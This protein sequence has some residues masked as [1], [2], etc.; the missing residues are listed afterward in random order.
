[1]AH[2]DD[3]DTWRQVH[4]HLTLAIA[5]SRDNIAAELTK[6]RFLLEEVSRCKVQPTPNSGGGGGAAGKK[7]AAPK[8][9]ATTATS[10]GKKLPTS[11]KPTQGAKALPVSKKSPIKKAM[12]VKSTIKAKTGKSKLL[13]T[14]AN[15][16]ANSSSDDDDI[17]DNEDEDDMDES[18]SDDENNY[19]STSKSHAPLGMDDNDSSDDNSD[20]SSGGYSDDSEIASSPNQKQQR[21]EHTQ[22]QMNAVSEAN[23]FQSGYGMGGKTMLRDGEN[24]YSED[25][26]SDFDF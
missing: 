15:L 18:D 20:D 10:K 3:L 8:K 17:L 6:R 25:E 9:A 24:Y 12:V 1:M 13:P 2:T 26:D 21:K 22:P 5:Q 4:R 16:S 23:N 19:K 14:R 7:K 11:K